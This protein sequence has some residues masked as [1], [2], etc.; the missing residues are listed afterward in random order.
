MNLATIRGRTHVNGSRRVHLFT[1]GSYESMCTACSGSLIRPLVPVL[2]RELCRACV[3]AVAGERLDDAGR[4][5]LAEWVND[6][7]GFAASPEST[8]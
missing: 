4:E 2:G 6:E 8:P 7:L 5:A 1:S 3:S